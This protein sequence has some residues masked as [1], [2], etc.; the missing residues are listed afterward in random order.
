MP[1]STL[2]L[3]SLLAGALGALAIAVLNHARKKRRARPP[4]PPPIATAPFSPPPS[5]EGGGLLVI[6]GANRGIGL[7][8]AAAFR[9]AGWDVLSLSRAPGAAPGAAWRD[10]PAEPGL[11]R[12]SARPAR[13]PAARV[14]RAQRGG[15]GDGPRGRDGRARCGACSSERGRARAAHRRAAAALAEGSSIAGARARARAARAL[16]E[17]ACLSLV[18]ARCRPDGSYVGSTLS[19]SGARPR[20]VG[21]SRVGRARRAAALASPPLAPPPCSGT[22]RR[23][24]PAELMRATCQDSRG[25]AHTACVCPGFTATEMLQQVSRL[26]GPRPRALAARRALGD[27]AEALA[28]PP[29]PP[30]HRPRSSTRIRRS[31]SSSSACR[32]SAA[33]SSPPRSPRRSASAPRAPS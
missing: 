25:A 4:K 27:E 14:R 13:A 28:P 12:G 18:G 30:G 7:A 29:P 31:A 20:V 9:D 19:R 8:T 16:L 2:H 6:S 11:G 1:R 5:R 17:R 33:S 10:R 32:P 23:S 24:T 3:P 15:H 22:S 26:V 21:V